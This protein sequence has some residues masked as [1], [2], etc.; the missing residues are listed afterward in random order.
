MFMQKFFVLV[1]VAMMML[2]ACGS[3]APEQEATL[4]PEQEATS[5]PEQTDPEF[6]GY[7]T[8]ISLL[9]DQSGMCLEGND[10]DSESVAG[11]AFMA[12]CTDPADGQ[13]W[14]LVPTGD[15]YYTLHTLFLEER[16]LCLEGAGG[17]DGGPAFM[18]DCSN[19]ATGQLWKLV[20]GDQDDYYLWNVN[21]EP[22]NM[23]L[24]SNDPDSEFMNGA[25]FMNDCSNPTDGQHWRFYPA[26]WY[27]RP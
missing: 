5:A 12:D 6:D 22:Q 19:P 20:D 4:A 25:A 14:K 15:G 9:S 16:N 11:A 17:P 18:A 13:L 3:Q 7:Y 27:P 24:E 26:E 2:T 1:V 21:L 10:P 23:C 8:M